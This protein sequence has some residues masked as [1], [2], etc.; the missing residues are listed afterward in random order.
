MVRAY[1]VVVVFHGVIRVHVYKR[2]VALLR[3]FDDEDGLPG[4]VVF[5][6]SRSL[7]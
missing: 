3:I 7:S 4:P 5:P 6:G 2:E 1:Y